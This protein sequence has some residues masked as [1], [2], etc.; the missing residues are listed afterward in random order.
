MTCGIYCIENKINGK[1]YIGQSINIENRFKQ[2]IKLLKANIHFNQY[3]QNTYN[4]HGNIFKF[5]LIK[6]CKS[7]YL[8]RFEKLYI[9]IYHTMHYQNGYNIEI[10][11]DSSPLSEQ[12]RK[13]LSDSKLGSK[14]PMYGKTH[15]KEAKKKISQSQRKEKHYLWNQHHSQ[16]TV[17]K[18]IKSKNSTGIQYVYKYINS[19]FKQG[20]QYVY[21][22]RVDKRQKSNNTKEIRLG[23]VDLRQL[24]KKV[25]ENGYSWNIID[26]DKARNTYEENDRLSNIRSK[27]SGIQYVCRVKADNKLGYIYS[28]QNHS[29]NINIKSMDLIELRNKILEV[30]CDWNIVNQELADVFFKKYQQDNKKFLRNRY[31]CGVKYLYKTKNKKSKTG[32]KYTYRI[33]GQ[34]INFSSINLDTLQ[35]KVISKGLLWDIFDKDIFNK[36]LLTN[37]QLLEVVKNG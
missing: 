18:I 6:T 17:D 25:I 31:K 33:S 29:K 4:K 10:G 26:I 35:K 24:E 2:H 7:R 22:F 20:F 28:Y 37:K 36:E 14:N 5:Y 21:R 34:N 32:F 27:K 19:D 15:T 13:K 1:K 3:L 16:K 23:S 11:G 12:T 9:R 30:G 8:N